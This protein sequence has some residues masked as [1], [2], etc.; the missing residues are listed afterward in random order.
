MTAYRSQPDGWFHLLHDLG[1]SAALRD[2][3]EAR[4]W[5]T[6]ARDFALGA[7]RLDLTRMA[8][9]ALAALGAS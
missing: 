2:P 7:G 5:V 1:L 3:D 8:D 9:G 4:H 6:R